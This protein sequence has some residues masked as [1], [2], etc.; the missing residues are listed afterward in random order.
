MKASKF[1]EAQ[2]AS[3]LKQAADGT[4]VC[5]VCRRQGFPRNLLHLWTVP[6]L[7]A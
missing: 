3:V 1:S 2:I 4:P 5:E 7:Q 6:L